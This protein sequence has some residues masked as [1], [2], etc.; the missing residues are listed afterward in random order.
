[1]ASGANL[2]QAPSGR[3]VQTF[4]LNAASAFFALDPSRTPELRAWV[5]V[6]SH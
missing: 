2:Q 5:S 1:M 3:F 6:R 4:T